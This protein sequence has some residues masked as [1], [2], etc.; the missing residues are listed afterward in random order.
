M[1]AAFTAVVVV[2]WL[3]IKY[4][5]RE[6]ETKFTSQ[7]YDVLNRVVNRIDE[8]NYLR[9]K[10]EM[11]EQIGEIKNYNDLIASQQ[12]G[13]SSEWYSNNLFNILNNDI[14]RL[15][16][17][18]SY[19]F[20][21]VP[22]ARSG[23]GKKMDQEFIEQ[24]IRSM[25]LPQRDSTARAARLAQLSQQ[26]QEFLIRLLHEKD[27]ENVSAEQRLAHIDIDNLLLYG[28]RT[29]NIHLPFTY[30]IMT[31]QGL[32]N[33][34]KGGAPKNFY[35]VELFQQDLVKKGYY[36]GVSFESVQPVLLENMGW[37]FLASGFCIFGLMFVFIITIVIHY[38][39]TEIIGHQE[40]F[41]Q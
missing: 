13:T 18:R 16:G 41:Y 3:W 10:Q 15:K 4:A 40:R 29:Y 9:Y 22:Y 14:N 30:E 34:V 31:K 5:I 37:L 17:E 6:R 23:I 2:Q 27:P 32:L 33:R 36:L 35:Y 24:T 26:M 11:N 8:F 19:L 28:F 12:G 1:M 38:A 7:V 25:E 39:S 20:S 21:V